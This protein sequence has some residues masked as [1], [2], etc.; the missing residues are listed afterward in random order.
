[1][2][3]DLF[4]SFGVN[5]DL[6]LE[7]REIV[8]GETGQ[9]IPGVRVDRERFEHGEVTI[10]HIVE[11]AAETIMGKPVG[12][13]ITIE[14]PVLRENHPAAHHEVSQILA[15]QLER[16]VA[17]IPEYGNILLVGLGNWRAT[18]DA[19]GPKVIEMS[20]VTRHLYNYAPQELKGGM[21]SVSALAPGVLGLTGIETAEIIKGVV[22]KIR[23]ELIIAIDSLAARSVTRICTTIQIADTGISPGSGIGNRRA[24]INRESMG[25]P[26]IAIG[27]PTVVHAAVI[28]QD[29]INAYLEQ[30]Q[31]TPVNTGFNPALAR[32]AIEQVLEPFGG[33]LTVTPKEIDAL[34]ATTAKVIAGGISLALHPGLTE[35]DYSYYLH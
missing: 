35:D 3:F 9:E 31:N 27:V 20:L 19:L 16:F 24:G 1:M 2:L 11:K 15:R 10:V 30:L 7:A 32:R 4:R 21:R 29:T 18:P 25:V 34:I 12:T 13:Y 6:A 8:R 26:V 14:A 5:L 22:E 33:N 28:S 17:H 23:P